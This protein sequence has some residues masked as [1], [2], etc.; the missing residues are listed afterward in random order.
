VFVVLFIGWNHYWWW[1]KGRGG[2]EGLP[3]LWEGEQETLCWTVYFVN[4]DRRVATDMPQCL[5]QL[6]LLGVVWTTPSQWKDQHVCVIT[7]IHRYNTNT[8][9]QHKYTGTTQTHSYNTNTQLQHKYTGTTQI[10]R[11]NTNTQVQ[12][13]HTVT[14]QIHR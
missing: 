2:H 13:K 4:E 7:Q 5:I 3:S 12:H 9:L 10:H 11:Y 6:T 8:Q 1:L 14:T